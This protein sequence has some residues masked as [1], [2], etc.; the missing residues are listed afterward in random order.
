MTA[1]LVTEVGYCGHCDAEPR[2]FNDGLGRACHEYFRRFGRL[3][4]QSLLVRRQRRA[5]AKRL[6]A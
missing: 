3:P 2:A 1:M 5:D 6:R 4:T